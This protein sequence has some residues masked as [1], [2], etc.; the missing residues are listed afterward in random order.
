MRERKRSARQL[1]AGVSTECAQADGIAAL[2][3]GTAMLLGLVARD[4]G[5]GGQAVATSMLLSNAYVLSEDMVEYAGRGP[6]AQPDAELF[7]LGALYRLYATAE[8]WV[9]LAAP[10]DE[11]WR[12]L[13]GALGEAGT[14]LAGDPRFADAAARRTNDAELAVALEGVFA[15]RTAAEWERRLRAADVGC[16]LAHEGPVEAPLQRADFGGASGLLATVEDPTFGEIPR[17]TPLVALS[18]TPGVVGPAPGLG[19]HTDAV[20]A[21]LG[22]PPEEI[23]RLRADGVLTG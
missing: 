22:H 3:V 14:R 23:A 5:A 9:F 4:R 1:A 20:L 2:A 12:R 18:R 7:G 10:K 8:G 11:E 15:T 21:E 6:I 16:V 17:L 19:E 13:T